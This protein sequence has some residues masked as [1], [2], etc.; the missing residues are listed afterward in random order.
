MKRA[1]K[2]S[3]AALAAAAVAA[4]AQASV[5]DKLAVKAAATYT[6]ASGNS[7][8][9]ANVLVAGVAGNG[10]WRPVFVEPDHEWDYSLGLS[11]RIAG[12]NTRFFVDYD[13]FRGEE[14][15][16]IGGNGVQALGQANAAGTVVTSAVEHKERDFKVGFVHTLH[17]G[18]KFETDLSGAIEY[19]KMQRTVDNQHRVG[20]A[21]QYQEIFNETEGWG[22][23]MAATGRV[24]PWGDQNR[25]WSFWA[26]AGVGL[27]YSDHTFTH[28]LQDNAIPPVFNDSS[29]NP[30]DTKSIVTRVEA[31]LG[32]EWNRVMRADFSD[33]QLGVR[34]GVRYHNV[35]N[36]FKNGN[37]LQI[38]AA[39][40]LVNINSSPDDYGRMG[41]FLEFKIG[42]ANA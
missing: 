2:F 31:D 27:L 14:T 26:R 40:A 32:V 15:R 35:N 23:F 5:I 21:V 38:P 30:E 3:L 19:A 22:P 17:F 41:P 16:E 36:A 6:E 28:R 12:H 4:P 34:L 20:V 13:H 24:Y 11:Y 29:M 18:P 10:V 33:L 8:N 1:L 9:F 25:C 7:L 39:N 42:G 37:L